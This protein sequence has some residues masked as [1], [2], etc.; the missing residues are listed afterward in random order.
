MMDNAVLLSL[1]KAKMLQGLSA[2]HLKIIA[3]HG[4]R[5]EFKPDVFEEVKSFIM[6]IES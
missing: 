3:A 4:N 6:A 2:E 5:I 1:K